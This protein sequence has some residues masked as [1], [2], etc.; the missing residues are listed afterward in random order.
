VYG[1]VE[2]DM[3]PNHFA[4]LANV[5][6]SLRN[7]RYKANVW[8]NLDPSMGTYGK[9]IQRVI[10]IELI[11]HVLMAVKMSIFGFLGFGVF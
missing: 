7:R 9:N 6:S 10:K 2:L 1:S 5:R 3:Q 4:I 8:G 11:Y